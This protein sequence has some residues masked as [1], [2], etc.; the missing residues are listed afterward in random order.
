MAIA[1]A[2]LIA[3]L[4]AEV[5]P[6]LMT[7]MASVLGP[8]AAKLL[9]VAQ[10]A[11]SSI[12]KSKKFKTIGKNLANRFLGKHKTARK[13]FRI[14]KGIFHHSQKHHAQALSFHD[15]LSKMNLVKHK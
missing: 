10:H 3:P 1:L 5:S 13:I 9:P 2:P 7:Q 11:L 15:Q 12:L 8:S 4:M 6:M 14:G